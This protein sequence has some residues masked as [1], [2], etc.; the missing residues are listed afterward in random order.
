MTPERMAELSERVMEISAGI[1]PARHKPIQVEQAEITRANIELIV[2]W[3]NS[4]DGDAYAEE[5]YDGIWLDTKPHG[6]RLCPL[7]EVIIRGSLGE[8]YSIT[9]ETFKTNYDDVPQGE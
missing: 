8:F 6:W 1:K 4:H 3:V 2:D 7:G 9:M 5:D